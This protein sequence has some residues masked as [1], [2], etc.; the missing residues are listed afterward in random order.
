MKCPK[1]N[2]VFGEMSWEAVSRA[3]RYAPLRENHEF[4]L[5]WDQW[6]AW[7]GSAQSQAK[8]PDEFQARVMFDIALQDPSRYAQGIRRAIESDWKVPR[9]DL[10]PVE[11]KGSQAASGQALRVED[12]MSAWYDA[13]GN[14]E[15]ASSRAVSAWRHAVAATDFEALPYKDKRERF[16]RAY[17]RLG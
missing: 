8:V 15:I 17:R 4:V 1:C 12:E 14:P 7:A 10:V 16:F 5:A 6:I 2:H 9:P 3:A 13:W 11:Q